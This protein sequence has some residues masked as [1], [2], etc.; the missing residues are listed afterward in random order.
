MFPETELLSISGLQHFLF[1][2]RQWALIHLEQLWS[3]NYLTASG[4]VLHEQVHN[5]TAEQ[6]GNIRLARTL[7]LVSQRLGLIGQA[8][9]VEFHR[10]P[11]GE[12]GVKLSGQKGQWRV[13]PVEYKH[14]KPKT[15]KSDEIQL[16]AQALCLE[17]M[18]QTTIPE[19]ALFYGKPRRRQI[20]ALTEELRQFTEQTARK[21]H[22]M[23]RLGITPPAVYTA[24]CK[25]CSLIEYCLPKLGAEKNKASGYIRRLMEENP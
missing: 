12:T 17:E 24:R 13:Y 23:F 25:S 8:D 22:E 21:I 18:L 11:A 3:E 10:L 19:G 7:N 2:R 14:G 4:R 9:L 6:R 5:A 15:D 1:C 20:V 16:C